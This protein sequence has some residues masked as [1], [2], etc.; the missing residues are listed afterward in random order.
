MKN[1]FK[2]SELKYLNKHEPVSHDVL[3]ELHGSE[4]RHGWPEV[5]VYHNKKIAYKGLVEHKHT[6]KIAVSKNH[7]RNI[8]KVCFTNKK[9]DDTV[10]DKQGNITHDKFVKVH[11]ITIDNS[12]I[13][14]VGKL[15]RVYIDEPSDYAGSSRGG[16]GMFFPGHLKLYYT[17]PPL[18][19]IHQVYVQQGLFDTA[20]YKA[21]IDL[22][23]NRAVEILFNHSREDH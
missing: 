15:C 16:N 10:V 20:E 11:S 14:D 5:E 22:N 13:D 4:G 3:I 19:Y 12:Y 23:F 7:T 18:D 2:D 6:L 1:L 21:D 17:N 8:F 9:P